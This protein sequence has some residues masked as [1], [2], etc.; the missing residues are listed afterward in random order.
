MK[1]R[2][3]Q[4]ERLGYIVSALVAIILILAMFGGCNAMNGY[5]RTYAATYDADN[6]SG[7][8]SLTLRPIAPPG[9]P[10]APVAT[11][12]MNDEVIARIVKLVSDEAR[13]NA[14]KPE[15]I[16]LTQEVPFLPDK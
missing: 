14:G 9:S 7:N 16:S 13:K 12:A 5:E 3:Q 11:E 2:I 8:I 6:Q 1:T 4:L 10:A 15:P